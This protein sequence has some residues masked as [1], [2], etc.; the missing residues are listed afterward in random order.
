V[1]RKYVIVKY[2]TLP[3]YI[4][5]WVVITV[6]WT[7]EEIHAISC[8]K[9]SFRRA[10]KRAIQTVILWSICCYRHKL[11]FKGSSDQHVVKC[12]REIRVNLMRYII[13]YNN[14]YPIN[15]INVV[16]RLCGC[17]VSCVAWNHS[18]ALRKVRRHMYD[19]IDSGIWRQTLTQV[20][21][22]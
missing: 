4:V 19:V 5:V 22:H 1:N 20:T 8:L 16:Q 12:H 17:R 21:I 2:E 11:W 18:L 10:G 13:T 3:T 15:V 7:I 14:T 9:R 6:G